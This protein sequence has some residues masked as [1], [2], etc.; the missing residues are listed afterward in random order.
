MEFKMHPAD[1]PDI[2]WTGVQPDQSAIAPLNE[3]TFAKRL[4][5]FSERATDMMILLDIK[6]RTEG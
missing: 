3:T 6:K 1:H 2:D 4:L 5:L